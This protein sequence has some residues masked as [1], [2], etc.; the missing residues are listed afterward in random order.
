MLPVTRW[1]MRALAMRSGRI[2]G[3]GGGTHPTLAFGD[4]GNVSEHGDTVNVRTIDGPHSPPDAPV[5]V[6]QDNLH[7]KGHEVTVPSDVRK[8]H[9]ADAKYSHEHTASS[10]QTI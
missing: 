4:D 5:M 9:S 6:G 1:K 10:K 3:G 7:E 2:E 8:S